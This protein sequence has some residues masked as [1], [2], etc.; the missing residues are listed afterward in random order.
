[1]RQRLRSERRREDFFF[2][3]NF[4]CIAD[5]YI[6]EINCKFAQLIK[7]TIYRYEKDSE[8]V[9]QFF[10]KLEREKKKFR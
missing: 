8:K 5:I 3:L 1:M 6:A 7:F 10:I 2:G 9:C 4:R